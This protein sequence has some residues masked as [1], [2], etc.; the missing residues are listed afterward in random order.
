M[1]SAHVISPGI[2]IDGTLQGSG[3]LDVQGEVYGDLVITGSV[4]IGSEGSVEGSIEADEVVISGRV[5]GP[6]HGHDSVRLEASASVQGD[7]T[8]E[9]LT[10]HP[11]ATLRGRVQMTVD[12]ASPKSAARGRR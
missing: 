6:I 9:H 7:L 11:Q 4:H 3:S 5:V 8:S 2:R 10:M 1:D 12:L